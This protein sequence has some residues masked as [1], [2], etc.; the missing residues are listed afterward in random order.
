MYV[1]KM[2]ATYNAT[3]IDNVIKLM[4]QQI[5]VS[6]HSV[7]GSSAYKLHYTKPTKDKQN[8]NIHKNIFKT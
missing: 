3:L 2:W 7:S 1:N 5:I 4:F 8:T 6:S